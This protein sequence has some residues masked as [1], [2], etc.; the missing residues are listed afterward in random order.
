MLL[1]FIW[2]FAV[3]KPWIV[4][5][6][7][8]GVCFCSVR[9]VA[10]WLGVIMAGLFTVYVDNLPKSMD[11]GWLRQLFIPFGRMEDVYM[12]SKRSSSFNT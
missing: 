8:L 2:T 7:C 12:P 6:K 5:A 4:I 10:S 3:F 9:L 11:V 1:G